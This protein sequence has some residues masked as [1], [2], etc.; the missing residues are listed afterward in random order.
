MLERERWATSALCSSRLERRVGRR[1]SSDGTGDVLRLDRETNIPK[2]IQSGAF[3][4]D[5]TIDGT[6]FAA[7]MVSAAAALVITEDPNLDPDR[8]YRLLC[9]TAYE[10]WRLTTNGSDT[11]EEFGCGLIDVRAAVAG[12]ESGY[13]AVGLIRADDVE[14]GN[15]HRWSKAK[16]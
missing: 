12:A 5:Y 3:D 16:P 8:G 11:L 9:S 13:D 14:S 10:A 6:S 7:P 2:H 1:R 4:D 15:L